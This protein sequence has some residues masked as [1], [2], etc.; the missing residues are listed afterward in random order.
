MELV[1]LEMEDICYSAGLVDI[2]L[3]IVVCD[4]TL[5]ELVDLL[6][7]LVSVGAGG[8][9]TGD[10]CLRYFTFTRNLLPKIIIILPSTYSVFILYIF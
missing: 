7:E 9:S 1:A 5:L 2:L 3:E 8:H 10:I 4:S 6:L